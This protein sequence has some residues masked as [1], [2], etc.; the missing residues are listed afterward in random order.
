MTAATVAGEPKAACYHVTGMDCAFRLVA[1]TETAA[2]GGDEDELP[3]DCS[4][5]F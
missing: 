1:K 2:A 3:K 4:H 5:M